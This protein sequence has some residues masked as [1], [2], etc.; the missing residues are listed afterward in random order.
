MGLSYPTTVWDGD[1]ANRDSD[2]NPRRSPDWQDWNRLVGEVAAV[3]N[4]AGLGALGGLQ[5]ASGCVAVQDVAAARRVVFTLTDLSVVITDAATKEWGG[6][7]IFDFPEGA[8]NIIGSSLDLSIVVSSLL[9]ATS[10]GDYALGT[11][12]ATNADLTG[13]QVD[14]HQKTTIA[15]LSGRAGVI[16][17]QDGVKAIMDGTTTAKDCYLNIIFDAGDASGAATV[18]V[19]GTI[20]LLYNYLG[21]Y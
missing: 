7:K 1:S 2:D 5:A 9:S 4:R 13:T 20:T 6:T 21:D 16:T 3:Q 18:T 8:I 15:V 14:L 12:I 19:N 11:T 17:G 10:N